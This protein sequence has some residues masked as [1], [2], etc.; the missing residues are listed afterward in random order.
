MVE[1][2][3]ENELGTIHFEGKRQSIRKNSVIIKAVT[4]LGLP[5]REYKLANYINC[6]GQEL[7]SSRDLARI[8]TVSVDICSEK[9]ARTQLCRMMEI[10]YQPGFLKLFSRSLHRKIFCRCT[11]I[12][13]PEKHGQNIVSLILQFT[14]DSPYFTDAEAQEAVL[15]KRTDLICKEFQLPCVFTKKTNRSLVCNRGGVPS[16]PVITISYIER[17]TSL[18]DQP[19]DYGILIM[20][21]SSGQ[22]IRLFYDGEP[23][24]T[25]VLNIPGRSIISNGTKDITSTLSS[26]SVL[27]N[28]CLKPGDN[29]IEIINFSIAKDVVV[30]MNYDNQYVEAVV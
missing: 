5:E 18:V 24:E 29:D 17:I 26:D 8:I 10:L 16:E 19:E 25:V 9:N 3:F 21:H 1:L 27:S 4:G 7:I 11:E 23:G 20:N 30:T 6:P 15:F 14:C 12:S 22:K 13:E 28:F 2:F